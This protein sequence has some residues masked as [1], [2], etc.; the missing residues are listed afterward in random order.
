MHYPHSSNIHRRMN[1]PSS[2][3][4]IVLWGERSWGRQED[5]LLDSHHILALIIHVIKLIYERNFKNLI[6]YIFLTVEHVVL[7]ALSG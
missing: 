1:G 3:R 7:A 6:S 4:D 2:H 5:S